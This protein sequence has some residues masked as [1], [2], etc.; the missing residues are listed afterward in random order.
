VDLDAFFAAI[1]QRDEPKF[2]NRPLIVGGNP[3]GRG[4]VSTCSYE[5][6]RYG[7]HSAMPSRQALELCPHAIFLPPRM[8][9]YAAVSRE[10]FA[11]FAEFS[12]LVEP[13]SV[14][15]AFLDV[16]HKPLG[17]PSATRLARQLQRRI[18]EKTRLTASAGVS[19]NPFLAKV[20]SGVQ[21]PSGLTVI[22]PERAREF[23]DAL[24]I[25]KFYGVGP[26]TAEKLEARQIFF[27][28]DLRALSRETLQETLGKM[29]HH[30]YDAVRGFDLRPIVPN[31]ER[32]SLSKE[33]TFAEDLVEPQDMRRELQK[34]AFAVAAALQL[35][36]L[37]G[38]T[39]TLKLRYDNFESVSRSTT[40]TEAV[41]DGAEIFS[42]TE[43][44]LFSR[45]A[46]P[47]RRVRLLGIGVSSFSDP[48]ELPAPRWIQVEFSFVR[49][50][51]PPR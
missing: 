46:V 23:L 18:W 5:A 33:T 30:L 43:E 41:V 31:R 26:A 7:V 48:E 17:E 21:K 19:F 13:L 22:P 15:E 4:V 49:S 25:R 50:L 20:A 34:L 1:E 36:N 45:T 44:L 6:R 24:P 12:H 14:D 40:L 10:I 51:L 47:A 11:I 3:W 42:L 28:A 9:H 8:E 2:R 27:G 35:E 29:G 39:V 37:R 32:Q 38:R 16:T